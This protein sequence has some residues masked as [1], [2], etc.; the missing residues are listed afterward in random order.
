MVEFFE[1][2]LWERLSDGNL[3]IFREK[4]ENAMWNHDCS[5]FH[6]A[7]AAHA[8]LED[9]SDLSWKQ[10]LS[11]LI[12]LESVASL[13][14]PMDKSPFFRILV[15]HSVALLQRV[16]SGE[17]SPMSADDQSCLLDLI[18]SLSTIDSRDRYFQCAERCAHARQVHC[19][20]HAESSGGKTCNVDDSSG[21]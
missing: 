20:N 21:K 10:R 12:V 17:A 14:D 13:D 4:I 2:S 15:Q 19:T 1:R 9:D 5:P 6:I 3:E 16:V 7:W 18:E 8:L 11:C